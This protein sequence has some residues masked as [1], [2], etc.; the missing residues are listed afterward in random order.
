MCHRFLWLDISILNHVTI[1]LTGPFVDCL[2]L[3]FHIRT[4][5]RAIHVQ[6][7]PRV[8]HISMKKT[9]SSASVQRDLAEKTV[10]KV[11]QLQNNENNSQKLLHGKWIEPRGISYMFS[12]WGQSWEK[13][14]LVTDIWTSFAI[15]IFRVKWIVASDDGIYAYCLDVIARQ[16]VKVPVIGLLLFNFYFR[17]VSVGFVWGHVWVV[18]KVLVAVDISSEIFDKC[19]EF[20]YQKCQ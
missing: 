5:V 4:H 6:I 16:N 19:S 7:T 10:T 15:V 2:F 12:G 9:A 1:P 3:L 13:L 17:S 8:S 14:L 20:V 18:C 11:S